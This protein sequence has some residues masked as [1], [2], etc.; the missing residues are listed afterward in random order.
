MELMYNTVLRDAAQWMLLTL[1]CKACTERV[2]DFQ[3]VV[4][5]ATNGICARY[6][7][8]LL[9]NESLGSCSCGIRAHQ[10]P[11]HEGQTT[12]S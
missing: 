7:G 5:T 10:S 3:C 12:H 2:R 4:R 11:Q 6:A 9:V 1:G 8:S